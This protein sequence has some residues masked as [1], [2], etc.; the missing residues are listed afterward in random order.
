MTTR[1]QLL[2]GSL[3]A[4][5]T[6]VGARVRAARAC[7]PATR[8]CVATTA[9]IEGPYYRSGAPARGDLRDPGD[10]RAMTIVLTGLVGAVAHCLPL[11]GATLDVWHADA[12]GAYDDEGMRHRGRVVS[13]AQGRYQLTTIW[14][15][16]YLNGRQHRPAHLHVKVSHP[17]APP[18]TTQLYFP[19]DPYN[20]RDAFFHPSRLMAV[21]PG[22]DARLRFRFDFMLVA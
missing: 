16:R 13:D 9:D 14:P 11:A 7:G 10:A 21:E 22:K 8:F 4:L 5:A 12:A 3:A 19:G 15:G 2:T 6:L 1:R 20:E 18:L 17:H